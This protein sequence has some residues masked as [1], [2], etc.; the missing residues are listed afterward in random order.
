VHNRNNQANP[1][2]GARRNF[3]KGKRRYFAQPC[4]VADDAIQID[5]HKMLCPFSITKKVSHVTTTVTK[6]SFCRNNNQAYYDNLHNRLFAD[7]HACFLRS[8]AMVFN[9]KL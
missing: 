6:M 5:V 4:Q 2:M 7:F 9:D 3:S 1:A 8:I